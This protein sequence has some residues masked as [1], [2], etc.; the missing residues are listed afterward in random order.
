MAPALAS[1]FQRAVGNPA[2]LATLRQV[3]S[4][5]GDDHW[6]NAS[7]ARHAIDFLEDHWVKLQIELDVGPCLV[8]VFRR[9]RFES[10]SDHWRPFV[11]RVPL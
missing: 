3:C 1:M 2:L 8:C 10:M 11:Q 6:P 5:L 9:I 4:V 7:R